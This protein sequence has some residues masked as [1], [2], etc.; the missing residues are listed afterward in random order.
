MPSPSL[1]K[2]TTRGFI[3]LLLVH[4]M[5]DGYGGF[6]AILKHK[7]LANLNLYWAGVIATGAT[8]IGSVLQPV[9]GHLADGGRHRAMIMIGLTLTSVGILTGPVGFHMDPAQPAM[10]V[11]LAMMLLTVRIGQGMFHPAGAALAGSSHAA[12]R[13]TVVAIFITGGMIG[14]ASSQAVYSYVYHTTSGETWWLFVPGV[15]VLGWF[16]VACPN[17]AITPPPAR[18]WRHLHD[19][20]RGIRLPFFALYLTQVCGSG[21]MMGLIFLLPELMDLRGYP[22]WM[23]H[24]GAMA[25]FIGGSVLMMAPVAHIADRFGQRRMLM[26]TLI[27]AAG[28]YYALIGSPAMPVAAFALLCLIAGGMLSAAGPLGIAFGQTLMPHRGSLV[29][30]V[31]MG[32]AWALGSLTPMLVGYLASRTSIGVVGSLQYLGL[33]A[34]LSP[35]LV[36]FLPRLDNKQS[37]LSSAPTS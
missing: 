32:F 23:V 12:R 31:L 8:F 26:V 24:G 13:S 5:I 7:D 35:G 14:F 6:W 15:A 4:T 17:Q 9:F 25:F 34:L 21:L 10:Y 18:S 36:L 19:D 33:L 2:L 37:P 27:I 16:A 22:D 11:I 20:L 30:G 29:S 3:A 1:N 28:T